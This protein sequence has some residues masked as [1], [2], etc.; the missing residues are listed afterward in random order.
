MCRVITP[1]QAGIH[2]HV[3]DPLSIAELLRETLAEEL[4]AMT[5]LSARWHLIEDEEVGHTL[6]HLIEDRRRS[7]ALLWDILRKTEERAFGEIHHH[8]HSH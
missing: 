7:I 6:S 8:G 2:S 1:D 5:E 4:Q 3:D